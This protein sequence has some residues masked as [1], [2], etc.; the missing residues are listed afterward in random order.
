MKVNWERLWS[1]LWRDDIDDVTWESS[2]WGDRG[3]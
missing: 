2:E 1:W 3:V